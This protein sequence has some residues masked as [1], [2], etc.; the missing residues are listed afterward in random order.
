MEH[1]A[2]DSGSDSMTDCNAS[3]LPAI[4]EG[5]CLLVRAAEPLHMEVEALSSLSWIS[6]GWPNNEI[7]LRAA[8]TTGMQADKSPW[9]LDDACV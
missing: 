5:L 1:A 4:V 7:S 2:L 6:V 8:G 3:S 9:L